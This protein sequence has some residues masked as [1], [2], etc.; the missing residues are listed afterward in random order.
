MPHRL[1]T[2][3]DSKTV[4]KNNKRLTWKLWVWFSDFCP[5]ESVEPLHKCKCVQMRVCMRACE[6]VCACAC[7]CGCGCLHQW[8]QERRSRI[9]HKQSF[10][11]M[12][13]VFYYC[14]KSLHRQTLQWRQF[15]ALM[16]S[17]SFPSSSLT[18]LE[19]QSVNQVKYFNGQLLFCIKK[20]KQKIKSDLLR[21]IRLPAFFLSCCL[22]LL[23]AA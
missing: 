12:I 11:K 1:L 2:F 22:S 20:A 10:E 13:T 5:L 6:G 16:C 14:K 3:K 9:L 4:F 17:F 7:A 8:Q 23:T 21:L 18:Y 19:N 15:W